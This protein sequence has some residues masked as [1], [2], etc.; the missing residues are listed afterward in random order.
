MLGGCRMQIK[1]M[2]SENQKLSFQDTEKNAT[3]NK[4]TEH[5]NNKK[6]QSNTIYVGNINLNQDTIAIKKL[7]SQKQAMKEI[8]EQFNNDQ[9]LDKG[10]ETRRDHQEVLTADMELAAKEISNIKKLKQEVQETYG[11]TDDSEEQKNL[12]LLERSMFESKE[13]TEEELK[14][15][16]NMGPLTEY[17][18]TALH[19]DAMDEI[20]QQRVD[21]AQ[22]GIMNESRTIS[23]INVARLKTHLMI[24]AQ[25]EAAEIIE[26]ASREV[27]GIMLQET[28][29]NFDV[30]QDQK[31][32]D[33]KKLKEATDKKEENNEANPLQN[34]I[35]QEQLL[36]DLKSIAEKQK[37]LEEDITGIVVD[38]QI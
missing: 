12:E 19:Y 32:E 6:S 24:D 13:L 31:I 5:S 26:A 25:K 18:K 4:A 16:E 3:K 38:E 2:Q 37:M 29:E 27:V 28:K 9:I 17:Q 23:S 36:K 35:S 34:E 33:A 11:V 1:N 22:S 8:L 20:W 10:I 7:H 30:E 15:L 21:K 14:Q